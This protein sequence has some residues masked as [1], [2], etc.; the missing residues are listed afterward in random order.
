MPSACSTTTVVAGYECSVSVWHDGR[1]GS[2]PARRAGSMLCR[3]GPFRRAG[4]LAGHVY[5]KPMFA[6]YPG[7][8]VALGATE[9]RNPARISV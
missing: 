4:V 3:C 5:R 2:T 1:C 8:R 7:D 6:V 9:G